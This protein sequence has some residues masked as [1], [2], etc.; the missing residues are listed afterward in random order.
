MFQEQIHKLKTTSKKAEAWRYTSLQNIE[1]GTVAVKPNPSV[2]KGLMPLPRFQTGCHLVFC[3][4]QFLPMISD[5]LPS[6]VEIS[7]NEKKDE[8][9]PQ[10][11]FQ[12]SFKNFEFSVHADIV[13][14]NSQQTTFIRIKKNSVIDEP[15]R[16]IHYTSEVKNNQR[17]FSS[18]HQKI[19]IEACAQLHITEIQ[20]TQTTHEWI[21]PL[22]HIF[23]E[24]HSRCVHEVWHALNSD[25]WF[26]P[27]TYVGVQKNAFY[28]HH[29]FT[30]GAEKL[31]ESLEVEL[32]GVEAGCE[33]YSLA[34]VMNGAHLDQNTA[35][36]HVAERTVTNQ[37]FKTIVADNG[38]ASFSGMID[39]QKEA[40]HTQA[41]QMNQNLLLSGKAVAN[42]RPQLK[43]KA[44][45]VKCSHGATV[46]QMSQEALFYL[47]SRGI[48]ESEARQM[49]LQGFAESVLQKFTCDELRVRAFDD[50]QKRSTL[51]GDL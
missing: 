5:P 48:P 36:T 49:L 46:G 26:F 13:K 14:K 51:G 22:T 8:H 20:I 12:E 32:A 42:T 37:I 24:P 28:A 30:H 23:L 34:S 9:F 31:R 11:P 6:G 18:Y 10:D 2:L 29:H 43:I 40:Q 27:Q 39:V 45:D 3:D 16:L 50:W 38:V 19:W 41:V 17:L 1:D 35:V 7:V 21:N 25:T 47:Q 4:G 15:L 33:L 44:D